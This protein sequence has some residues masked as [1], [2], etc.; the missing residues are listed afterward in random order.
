M[1]MSK[2]WFHIGKYD[3]GMRWVIILFGFKLYEKETD[4]RYK[5]SSWKLGQA[6]EN[7]ECGDAVCI[8]NGKL[9]KI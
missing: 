4:W 6:G 5:I 8:K 9:Y 2:T 3:F 1:K 7:I